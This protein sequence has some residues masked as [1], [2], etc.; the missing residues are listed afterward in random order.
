MMLLPC[1][2]ADEATPC[3]TL[4]QQSA[5]VCPSCLQPFALDSKHNAWAAKWHATLLWCMGG[6]GGVY[7]QDVMKPLP[8]YHACT[9]CRYCSKQNKKSIIL[10]SNLSAEKVLGVFLPRDQ[11]LLLRSGEVWEIDLHAPK[12]LREREC[13]LEATLAA[14]A[15]EVYL[16]ILQT[17][18]CTSLLISYSS[19]PAGL[20][21]I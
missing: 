7:R 6:G 15:I 13:S 11:E 8:V 19:S 20:S 1:A 21:A 4:P 14:D 18:L 17:R 10:C 3:P 2:G 12:C 16:K 9:K 5:K